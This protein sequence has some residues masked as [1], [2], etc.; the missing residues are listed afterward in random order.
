MRVVIKL[1]G[2]AVVMFSALVQTAQASV[3]VAATRIVFPS[4]QRE[5]TIKVSNEGDSPSL[6]Q[7][8]LDNG[9]INASP[10]TIDVP[11]TLTPA[12][13]RLDPKKGQTLRMIYSKA[14]L[15][16][17]KET[18]FWLN[19]L[20]IPPKLK[21]QEGDANQL[22]MAFRTRIKVFF[23]PTTLEGKAADAPA[24]VIWQL[25]RSA[26]ATGYQLKAMNPTPYF[27]NLGNLEL[28]VAG[29]S[30]DAGSGYIKPGE[31]QLFPV[32]GLKSLPS[33]GAEVEYN[34]INDFGAGVR[35]QAQL[36]SMPQ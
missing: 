31:S 27:V 13:F 36:K 22:Q 28:K 1:L 26:D 3:V 11:F 32:N 18:L 24:K 9:E 16:Q 25:I 29:K 19:V 7:A 6:I 20:E 34:A 2:A 35:A 23:R 30:L 5:V 10:D 8:W 4:E 14:P 12:M 21:V 15:A 17:D 33:A